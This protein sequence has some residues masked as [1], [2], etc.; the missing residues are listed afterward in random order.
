MSILLL[1]WSYEADVCSYSS[2]HFIE[3]TEF[4]EHWKNTNY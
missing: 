3:L 4:D 1:D 2:S